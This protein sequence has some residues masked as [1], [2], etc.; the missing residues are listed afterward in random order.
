MLLY[1]CYYCVSVLI[2]IIICIRFCSSHKIRI[3]CIRAVCSFSLLMRIPD[4]IRVQRIGSRACSLEEKISHTPER[5][6]MAGERKDDGTRYPLKILLE[7]VPLQQRN[8][9]MDSFAKILW[10]LPTNDTSSLNVGVVS[11]K[12][13]INI[14]IPIFECPIDTDVADKWLNLLEVYFSVHNFSNRENITFFLLKP[15]RHVKYWWD[16]FCEK[17]EAEEP[18]LF[19][20]MVTWESFREVMKE[21]YYPVRS[22]DDLYTKWIT[23]Q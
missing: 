14:E 22:Y 1:L 13:H 5:P 11:F 2:I 12:V 7:K 3:K 17:R 20:V 21:Q 9:M 19:T 8:G 23:L 18:S 4:K 15:V 6:L 10:W 16:T